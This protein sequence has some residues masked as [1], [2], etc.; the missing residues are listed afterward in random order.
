MKFLGNVLAVIVGLLVFTV[1]SFFI[2]VGIIA[3][4]SSSDS[5]VKI[6]EK[7]VL[8]LDLNGRSIVER[9]NDDDIDL[10]SFG[11]F[12]SVSTVG[13]TNLKTAITTAK[14]QD[15]VK[16]IYLRTGMVFAGQAML[17][18]LRN[19]LIAFKESGKFIIAYDEIYSESGY[20]LSS[21]ADEVYL[22]PQGGIEYNGFS[23]EITF[24]KGLFEKLEVEP[25]VFRVGEFKSAVE[26]FLLDKMSEENRLQTTAFLNDL[27][28][29]AISK[30]ADSRGIPVDSL[31]VIN[32]KMLV[33]KNKDALELG[34]VDG[35]WYEDQVRDLIKEKLE[36]DED[37]KINTINVTT[38]NKSAKSKNKLSKNKIAVIIA[39]GE[40]VSGKSEGVIASESLVQEINKAKNDKDIKAIVLR[41]NSPG[42]SALAS[43]VIWRAL[44]EAK[45]E[46]PII[47]SMSEVAASG[48]YYI[49][50]P[51]DTIFAQPNT[52]TGSIGIFGL[53]FNAEGLLKNKLGITTDVVKT[54]ELSDFLSVTRKLTDLEKSIYQESV[55][56]GYDTFISRVAEGRSMEKE[57][58]LQVASGRVW[59]GI[60][61]KENGL[62]DL[63]GGLEDAIQVAAAKAEVADDFKIVY[64]PQQKT[65]FETL[66][67]TIGNDVQVK[68]LKNKYGDLYPI[69]HQL[70]KLQKYE[71]TLYRTP[72]DLIIK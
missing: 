47:A 43:E 46:K 32:S 36:L 59:S 53:W 51:A 67:S 4:A 37:D 21:V 35:L 2:L 17:E 29:F 26:P 30:V 34:L 10:S 52:I 71:G 39:E 56:D 31:K 66:F 22:N 28:D 27:N 7:T 11:P 57:Q 50:A 20:F 45:K 61:A 24:F 54:G 13:L 38:I 42:G 19:E 60:Q 72:Y 49:A 33:R 5:E 44:S 3:I 58:V 6:K 64:L 48:G 16:G 41:I 40:I 63:L 25:V 9:T 68:Y 8:V 55:N 65:W 69:I 14:E 15:D 62:V 18:E 1:L 70:D 12:T 23:S